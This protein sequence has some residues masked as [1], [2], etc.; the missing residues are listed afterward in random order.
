MNG[1]SQAGSFLKKRYENRRILIFE[2]FITGIITG[3]VIAAFRLTIDYMNN[4]RLYMYGLI[5]ENGM[6]PGIAAAAALTAA[7]LFIGSIIKKYPMIKG[8]GVAQIEGVFMQ[9]LRLSPW[10]E[11]PLKFIGGL[12]G[13]GLGLSVGR[14]GPSV[15]LGAYVG[16]AVER[17][18]KR[19]FTERVCLITA[20]AAAGLAAT[21]NAPFAA[22]VFALE[23]LHQY[24][25]PLLLM[26]V[27]AGAFAGDLAASM[28]VGS[29]PIF[30]FHTELI[31]PAPY[32]IWLIGLGIFVALVG[33]GFKKSIYF[34]QQLYE[35][36]GIPP[37]LRPLFP[38]LLSLP[39]GLWYGYA[40]GGG[41]PLI[42]A[43]AEQTFPVSTLFIVLAVKIIFT[44]ISAGSGAIGGIFVPLL[45]CGAVTGMLYAGILTSW[46]LLPAAQSINM[47]MFG[48]AACFTAVIK[49]PLTACIIV[50]ETTGSINHLSGLVLTCLSAYLTANFIGSQA[51]DHVLLTQI[52]EAE[53]TTAEESGLHGNPHPQ[54]YELPVQP[55]SPAALKKISETVWPK[56]CLIVG[57]VR[58]DHELIP[59]GKTT[60]YPGDKLI[61][62]AKS[63]SAGRLLEELAELTGSSS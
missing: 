17:I 20:G 51:H 32:L 44:G 55:Q 27:M 12:L 10:P 47:L 42:E 52:L 60:L 53:D 2:S 22:V 38:F 7:G 25:S 13:I 15:Q 48:M 9:K 36:L 31:Y 5:R 8:S 39:V 43:L 26:C 59:D 49:A 45:A 29:G 57:I 24:L 63:P 54:I 21:F 4:F 61:I 62:L 30:H 23:D 1:H 34:F 37:A 46:G 18:G 11:L 50:F 6:L 28:L 33:H 35:K 3:L 14:E 40:G 19:S 56:D 58:G 16:D 41:D